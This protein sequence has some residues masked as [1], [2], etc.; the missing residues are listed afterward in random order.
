MNK[1]SLN[2]RVSVL[3]SVY[4]TPGDYLREAID[5]VINQTYENFEFIIIDD[6]SNYKTKEILNHYKS[7]SRVLIVENDNNLGLTKNLNKAL[8]LS[9]GEYIARMDA[10]DVCDLSRFQKQV[11]YLDNNPSI[12]MVGTFYTLFDSHSHKQIKHK[13][14]GVVPIEVKTSLFFSNSSIMHSSVMMRHS[15][16]N[17][18]C[19]LHYDECFPKSQDFELWSR[20][21]HTVDISIIPEYLMFYRLSDNQVSRVAS[22]EQIQLKQL[23]LIR[24]LSFLI[25]TVNEC[26]KQ[27]H[28]NFCIGEKVNSAK[29]VSNW[30]SLLINLNKEK[31]L[32]PEIIYNYYVSRRAL[33]SA[34]KSC[35]SFSDGFSVITIIFLFLVSKFKYFYRAL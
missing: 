16:F 30:A 32:Y 31:Q 21:S 18:E 24:Q 10:D 26:Q 3:M 17:V 19:G 25:D 34:V 13:N 1:Q 6:N 29:S 4:N 22:S 27:L 7:D 11:E 23:I 33:K 20:A 2:P 8:S 28:C 12:A 15:I 35:I 14:E 9:K 5:S